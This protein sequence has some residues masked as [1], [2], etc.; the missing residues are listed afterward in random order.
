MISDYLTIDLPLCSLVTFPTLQNMLQMLKN[1]SHSILH[2]INLSHLDF[3]LG[4]PPQEGRL[5][6][7][8]GGQSLATSHL[9]SLQI[10]HPNFLTPLSTFLRI[11]QFWIHFSGSLEQVVSPAGGC[12]AL[13]I[14]CIQ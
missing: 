4:G 14:L 6:F 12:V 5:L 10:C 11:L 1:Q 13:S 7:P 8:Y 9:T 2:C 3:T